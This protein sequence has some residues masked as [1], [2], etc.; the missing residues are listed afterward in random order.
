M[1]GQ[2]NGGLDEAALVLGITQLMKRG[3]EHKD[4]N[5]RDPRPRGLPDEY[6]M[7]IHET[8]GV[9]ATGSLVD[10]VWEGEGRWIKNALP[11][12]IP[13]PGRELAVKEMMFRSC[14]VTYHGYASQG[15]WAPVVDPKNAIPVITL[16]GRSREGTSVALRIEH[17]VGTT[18]YVEPIKGWTGSMDMTDMLRKLNK[19]VEDSIEANLDK[20]SNWKTPK[21]WDRR[22]RYRDEFARIRRIPNYWVKAVELDLTKK[23][24]KYYNED[25]LT[26]LKIRAINRNVVSILDAKLSRGVIMCP[27][28]V[29]RAQPI[30]GCAGCPARGWR[31]CQCGEF[32]LVDKPGDNH[33]KCKKVVFS[34][35]EGHIFPI[36]MQWKNKM[37]LKIN[38]WISFD[39]D[40]QTG[41]TTKASWEFLVDPADIHLLLNVNNEPLTDFSDLRVGSF[42]LEMRSMPPR[43]D[44]DIK[45]AIEPAFPQIESA[46]IITAGL[47]LKV[48]P[49]DPTASDWN[50]AIAVGPVEALAADENG[51][52]V[53]VVQASTEAHLLVILLLLFRVCEIDLIT[54][55]NTRG[56]DLHWLLERLAEMFET[57]YEMV[58]RLLKSYSLRAKDLP[59]LRRCAART[60]MEN[61]VDWICDPAQ[62]DWQDRLKAKRVVKRY[63]KPVREIRKAVETRRA[64]RAEWARMG[65][66]PELTSVSGDEVAAEAVW[67]LLEQFPEWDRMMEVADG[68]VYRALCGFMSWYWTGWD[69]P[70]D[71]GLELKNVGYTQVS[72]AGW[73]S[74]AWSTIVNGSFNS[75]ARGK[76][77]W[78]TA[79]LPGFEEVDSCEIAKKEQS[80]RSSFRLKEVLKTIRAD[81]AKNKSDGDG[82][83]VDVVE[84][85]AYE[86]IPKMHQAAIKG[87]TPR[88][89]TVLANYVAADAEGPNKFLLHFLFM[90]QYI[91]ESRLN[92]ISPQSLL[93]GQTQKCNALLLQWA[94]QRGHVF[95]ESPVEDQ[96]VDLKGALVFNP[97]T[98][99]YESPDHWK[100]GG[101][102]GVLIAAP[103]AS[104]FAP[105]V[106]DQGFVSDPLEE[107]PFAKRGD[108]RNG[109][110]GVEVYVRGEWRH[111]GVY[112]WGAVCV[113]DGEVFIFDNGDWLSVLDFASLYPSIMEKLNVCYTTQ[114]KVNE[115]EVPC[116]EC[117]EDENGP[118]PEECEI[119]P[120][121][122]RVHESL[123]SVLERYGLRPDQVTDTGIPGIILVKRE[124]TLGMIPEISAWLKAD[125]R[126]WKKRKAAHEKLAK[127]VGKPSYKAQ[128]K[129]LHKKTGILL[130]PQGQDPKMFHVRLYNICEAC[131]LARKLAGNSFYGYLGA[132][133]SACPQ[134]L[135]AQVVTAWGMHDIVQSAVLAVDMLRRGRRVPTNALLRKRIRAV[136]ERVRQVDKEN[137]SIPPR[138][139]L[140]PLQPRGPLM[141]DGEEVECP[142]EI[143]EHLVDDPAAI[144]EHMLARGKALFHKVY[145]EFY[146]K[147]LERLNDLDTT[148]TRMAMDYMQMAGLEPDE[149]EE[150]DLFAEVGKSDWEKTMLAKRRRIKRDLKM[151]KGS[152]KITSFFSG[153]AE[154]VDEEELW[155]EGRGKTDLAVDAEY[156]PVF[157]CPPAEQTD[158]I[159]VC[160]YARLYCRVFTDNPIGCTR[161][162]FLASVDQD[163]LERAAEIWDS[164]ELDGEN[165]VALL[166]EVEP[167]FTVPEGEGDWIKIV[168]GDTDSIFVWFHDIPLE[169][170]Q[171]LSQKLEH[172]LNEFYA[173]DRSMSQEAEK[174][175]GKT[176]L[177]RK[178]GYTALKYLPC[179]LQPKG[180]SVTG[181]ENKRRGTCLLLTKTLNEILRIIHEE[182]NPRSKLLPY[183][184]EVCEKLMK[185]EIPMSLL[186]INKSLSKPPDQYKNRATHIEVA[187]RTIE[188]GGYVA[189]GSRVLFVFVKVPNKK[190]KAYER[191]MDPLRM[192]KSGNELDYEY[193]L[194]NQLQKPICRFLAPIFPIDQ[195]NAI[196]TKAANENRRIVKKV[197]EGIFGRRLTPCGVCQTETSQQDRFTCGAP[198]CEEGVAAVLEVAISD[199]ERAQMEDDASWSRCE[200]CPSRRASGISA[201]MCANTGCDNWM[202]RS[203]TQFQVEKARKKVEKIRATLDW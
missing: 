99:L 4:D 92:G 79:W 70:R 148:V 132:A 105:I 115:N 158:W 128:L 102:D 124:L 182:E 18:F 100:S 142:Y 7:M 46:P 122:K 29:C 118:C 117:P 41:R 134:L 130:P 139:R 160:R 143:P 19:M 137:E 178:K 153:G 107:T 3:L 50:V 166:E 96:H 167:P 48:N 126:K 196:F 11:Q 45:R 36:D 150:D 149:D 83:V 136:Q 119:A 154:P 82:L 181:L 127:L 108:F 112:E 85:D 110:T 114:L 146:E 15:E 168:Y 131:Q 30:K 164:G 186:T 62:F 145:K 144:K 71:K 24:V 123:E 88:G 77:R 116:A 58:D 49:A 33:S 65:I 106:A 156:P 200:T 13:V 125:R 133:F 51:R 89:N 76:L 34:V 198:E 57:E 43:I 23:S 55:W 157:I 2:K 1:E 72:R 163:K 203:M 161:E 87:V 175:F 179:Q 173:W 66:F 184:K 147:K 54:G 177:L 165:G 152:Q 104:D 151:G 78:K 192:I 6:P 53:S 44:G 201:D 75:R 95:P 98:G 111:C 155:W 190:A 69:K 90:L 56:F 22:R 80:Q 39:G 171:W 199:A 42:D 120:T 93:A 195:I 31:D 37:G 35:Y 193:Y 141:L 188:Q 21:D 84:L 91:E 97:R 183:V 174:I 176:L 59:R 17:E 197:K 67:P 40:V 109:P 191:G 159:R 187:M 121:H 103:S 172:A 9:A 16:L 25:C 47:S 10:G 27:W 180:A 194:T 113:I 169:V 28:S 68:S 86:H 63:V 32:C 64:W 138:Q 12:D 189:S 202:A 14:E 38:Q 81:Q 135:L 129:K 5:I 170:A 185:G 61:D 101:E 20:N 140:C 73:Q 8:E 52:V 26:L 74:V 94:T 162:S 60:I